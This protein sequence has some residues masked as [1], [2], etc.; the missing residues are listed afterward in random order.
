MGVD[1]CSIVEESKRKPKEQSQALRTGKQ[2]WQSHYILLETGV[3]VNMASPQFASQVIQSSYDK[4]LKAEVAVELANVEN[5][6]IKAEEPIK[7]EGIKQEPMDEV[8]EPNLVLTKEVEEKVKEKLA[9]T[10]EDL[11][12]KPYA[13]AQVALKR[14]LEQ[15]RQLIE[16]SIGRYSRALSARQDLKIRRRLCGLPEEELID[17]GP[18]VSIVNSTVAT[19]PEVSGIEGDESDLPKVKQ[20]SSIELAFQMFKKATEVVC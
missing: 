18:P 14:R 12:S 13:F 17:R 1:W 10:D 16:G 4:L 6:P 5:K 3:S 15:R 19:V 2:K 7:Q 8:T 11:L 9:F 20:L